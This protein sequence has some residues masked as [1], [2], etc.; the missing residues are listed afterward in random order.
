M[1]GGEPFDP[2]AERQ[3]K[4]PPDTGS[5]FGDEGPDR[6]GK[7]PDTGCDVCDEDVLE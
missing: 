6:R 7:V 2:E 1:P 4:G 5:R 3:R